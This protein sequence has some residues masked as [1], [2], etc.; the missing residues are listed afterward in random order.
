VPTVAAEQK[1]RPYTSAGRARV[2]QWA[3]FTV[4]AAGAVTLDTAFSDPG[5]TLGNFTTGVAAFA[6]PI[7]P[8]AL[9][10]AT[11]QPAAITDNMALQFTAQSD[12]AGTA[13]LKCHVA[14]TA[15]SPASGAVIYVEVVSQRHGG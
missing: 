1:A 5:L 12:S 3:R 4:G 2:H 10:R 13:T 15:T 9:L 6:F 7:S 11:L 8:K 14:G